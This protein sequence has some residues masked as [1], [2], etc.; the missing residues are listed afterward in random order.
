MAREKRTHVK[1]MTV[2]GII[3]VYLVQKL[4]KPT[5]EDIM[6]AVKTK[7][8]ANIAETKAQRALDGAKKANFITQSWQDDE[9]G[10][11]QH[12]YTVRTM[13]WRTPPEIMQ[14]GDLLPV[15]VATEE[16]KTIKAWFD[17]Q[18]G[19]GGKK[20]RRNALRDHHFYRVGIVFTDPLPGSQPMSGEVFNQIRATHG[21]RIDT[22]KIKVMNV[23]DRDF[24]TG[25]YIMAQD[26]LQ[27]WFG[28][29]CAKYAEL[30]PYAGK[31]IA[32]K[33]IRF[34]PVKPVVQMI[35][36]V[37]GTGPQGYET[38]QPPQPATIEFIAPTT[39][40]MTKEQLE[41]FFFIAGTRPVHGLSPSRGR[42]F[43]RFLVT[44]FEDLGPIAGADLSFMIADIQP[45]V[46]EEYGAYAK[47]L[48]SRVKVS[49]PDK[50]LV[51][52]EA[53]EMPALNGTDSNN[54][55]NDSE[56]NSE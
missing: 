24:I 32:F 41:V 8:K 30:P 22:K 18:E 13:T 25:E 4:H 55:N 51:P 17:A 16:A 26:V 36:P 56:Q 12:V 46:L 28:S 11:A 2:I 33:P 49:M 48:V 21:N 31:L 29:N 34:T 27:G 1:D 44:S 54:D 42:R 20:P 47:D 38:I 3:M 14:I 23:W 15:L 39:G 53:G 45:S 52:A 9:D 37:L 19:K 43:G 50:N 40:F 35:L 5:L 7:L 10:V 6:E